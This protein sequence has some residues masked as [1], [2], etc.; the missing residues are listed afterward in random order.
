MQMWSALTQLPLHNLEIF[1][2]P[3]L[4]G[5]PKLTDLPHLQELTVALSETE[6]SKHIN[7][8]SKQKQDLVVYFQNTVDQAA[9]Q[10]AGYVYQQ[11]DSPSQPSSPASL[12]HSVTT[13]DLSA[14]IWD[15]AP[16]NTAG[17]SLFERMRTESV[18]E[19]FGFKSKSGD[20]I[21]EE[22]EP[23]LLERMRTESVGDFFRNKRK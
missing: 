15:E 4:C 3:N 20:E 6:G 13:L 14:A 21:T 12:A 16:E 10:Q 1:N 8:L 22:Q 23:S 19:F 5:F 7:V 11:S 18:T 17:P 2:A 9:W